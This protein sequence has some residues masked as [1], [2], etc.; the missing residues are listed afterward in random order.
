M[1]YQTSFNTNTGDS[2]H[3]NGGNTR[4]SMYNQGGGARGGNESGVNINNLIAITGLYL[5]DA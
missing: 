4:I 1:N 5:T 3:C 2:F